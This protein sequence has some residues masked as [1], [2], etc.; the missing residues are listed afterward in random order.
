MVTQ[1]LDYVEFVLSEGMVDNDQI[2]HSQSHFLHEKASLKK[3]FSWLYNRI[4]LK[5]KRLS[6]NTTFESNI[7]W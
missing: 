3:I 6:T 5:I 1:Q 2:F 4:M 7:K